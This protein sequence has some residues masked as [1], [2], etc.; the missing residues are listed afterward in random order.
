MEKYKLY[1][2]VALPIAIIILEL[3]FTL[4]MIC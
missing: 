4:W 3:I 1:K 2:S